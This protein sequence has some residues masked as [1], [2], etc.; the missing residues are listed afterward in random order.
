[1]CIHKSGNLKCRKIMDIMEVFEV[2]LNLAACCAPIRG[3]QSVP[4]DLIPVVAEE[5][6]TS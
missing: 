2:S 5:W 1:M 6:Q 4:K 3:G